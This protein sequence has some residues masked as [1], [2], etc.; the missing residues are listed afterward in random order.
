M[1]RPLKFDIKSRKGMRKMKTKKKTEGYTLI[2]LL[3]TGAII[4][5]IA[6]IV[7]SIFFDGE[8]GD[9]EEIQQDEVQIE[10]PVEM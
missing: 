7:F 5:V 10:E 6:T 2:E 8:R 4:A 3:V 9:A 1:M